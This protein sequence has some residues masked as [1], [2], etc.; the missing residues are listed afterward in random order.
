MDARSATALIALAVI[1]TWGA[2]SLSALSAGDD[3]GALEQPDWAPPAWLFGPV[4]TVLYVLIAVAG[5]LAWRELGT[6]RH[7]AMALYGGQLVV[8]ALWTPLFFAWELRG[9]ALAWIILLDLLVV[10][11]LVLFARVRRAAAVLLAP[12]LAWILFA[13]ALNAAVWALNR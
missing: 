1:A 7:P 3:Y 2:G 12:Y 9:L 6:F 5:I 11:T 10:A 13:T 4:W 8:N